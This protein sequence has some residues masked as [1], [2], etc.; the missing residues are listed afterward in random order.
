MSTEEDAAH[1][2]LLQDV[3]EWLLIML[4]IS[5]LTNAILLFRMI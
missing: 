4:F 2:K 3:N 1:I 5:A